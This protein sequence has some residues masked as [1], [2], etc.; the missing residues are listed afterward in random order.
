MPPASTLSP[1]SRMVRAARTPTGS[2]V[3]PG[4]GEEACDGSCQ[5][6]VGLLGPGEEVAQEGRRRRRGLPPW[7]P[8]GRPAARQRSRRCSASRTATP[9]SSL[10]RRSSQISSS[11]ATGSSWEVGSSRRTRRGRVTRAAARAT[12]WS[13]PPE[14]VSTVR[15]SRCGM[16]S[17]RATS[18]TARARDGRRVPAH[19][20]RQLD[21]GRH[22]GRDD[23][24]LGVLGDVADDRGQLA[25]AG[26]DR[27]EA[28][29]VDAR[30]R[31][32]RRG[33]AGRGRRRRGAGSTCRRPSGRRAGR[34]RRGRPRARRPPGR[35]DRRGDRRR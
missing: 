7:R 9:H 33:S 27:V 12:R 23:L 26:L 2:G 1:A 31:S 29:D 10:R 11:P 32:R 15:S 4:E 20:Q 3:D 25:G 24:G 14:R 19:L 18:S 13:S 22:R 8:P 34:T 5:G 30:R 21:L 35:G 28:G 6:R 17:A 16:A